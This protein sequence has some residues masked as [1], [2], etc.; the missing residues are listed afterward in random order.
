MDMQAMRRTLFSTLSWRPSRP[1][2]NVLEPIVAHSRQNPRPELISV[3]YSMD[4]MFLGRN[5]RRRRRQTRAHTFT[6]L[7]P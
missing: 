3:I 6:A 7:N 2:E 4:F 5:H 1:M